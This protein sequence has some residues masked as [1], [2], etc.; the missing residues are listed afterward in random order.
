[1]PG[2]KSLYV[3]KRL[4]GPT[5]FA[6]C[7]LRVSVFKPPRGGGCGGQPWDIYPKKLRTTLV[8]SS[9]TTRN[10]CAETKNQFGR[11]FG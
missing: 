4:D 1:M 5:I 8:L 6:I 2:L 10:E 3:F 9:K 11:M 7:A